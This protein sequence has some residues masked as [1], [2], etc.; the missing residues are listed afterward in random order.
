MDYTSNQWPSRQSW[1]EVSMWSMGYLFISGY[2]FHF[3]SENM[4]YNEKQRAGWSRAKLLELVY[5]NPEVHWFCAWANDLTSN[6]LSVQQPCQWA[7]AQQKKA[8]KK[9]WGLIIKMYV[10]GSNMNWEPPKQLQMGGTRNQ[11]AQQSPKG[12]VLSQGL[13]LDTCAL[14]LPV[15]NNPIP[16]STSADGTW[17]STCPQMPKETSLQVLAL[18]TCQ[19]VVLKDS[20]CGFCGLHE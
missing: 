12:G 17:S 14:C 4:F 1:F 3:C 11:T 15:E 9:I 10:L 8:V 20:H 18:E 13:T 16:Y 6:Y 19:E 5:F 7:Q 2:Y